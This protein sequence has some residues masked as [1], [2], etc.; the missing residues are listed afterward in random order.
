[1]TFGTIALVHCISSY[2]FQHLI[3]RKTENID[4]ILV[5]RKMPEVLR[6]YYPGG[7]CGFDKEG[8]PIWIGEQ[9]CLCLWIVYFSLPLQFCLT[10]IYVK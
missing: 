1:M 3:W 2:C 10:F 6:K 7:H 8:C 9:F 5:Q 4:Q